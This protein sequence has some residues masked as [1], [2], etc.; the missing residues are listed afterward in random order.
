MSIGVYGIFFPDKTVYV[1]S[2]KN[3]QR[4][5][6]DHRH[7]AKRRSNIPGRATYLHKKINY[8]GVE[9]IKFS[10]IEECCIDDLLDREFFFIESYGENCIN[11]N[12]NPFKHNLGLKRSVDA[13]NKAIKTRNKNMPYF[14]IRAKRGERL[15]AITNNY[16]I[17]SILTNQCR[18]S[19]RKKVKNKQNCPNYTYN[20][21]TGGALSQ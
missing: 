6:S 8:Y 4:R 5:F 21:V 11:K 2:S 18:D 1:G 7:D 12:K 13:I 17:A 9:N 20:Y 10:I 19:L 16:T 14:E 3:C 15:V